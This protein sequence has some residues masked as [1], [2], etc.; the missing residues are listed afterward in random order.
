MTLKPKK[1]MRPVLTPFPEELVDLARTVAKEYREMEDGHHARMR[2]FLGRAYHV[3]R[4]FQQV[5]ESFEELKRDPFWELSRQKPKGLTTSKWVLLYV[6]RAETRNAR[7]RA[8]TYAKILDGF[9]RKKVRADQVPQ[10]IKKLGGIPLRIFAA[11][12]HQ[13]MGLMCMP[14]VSAPKNPSPRSL[15]PSLA[16]GRTIKDSPP[17]ISTAS[18]LHLVDMN[19]SSHRLV[20]HPASA[21]QPTQRRELFPATSPGAPAT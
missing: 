11:R 19:V 4:S 2:A 20:K 13:V 7:T 12:D 10:R 1:I 3:Y 17:S 14:S 6:M 18:R 21:I 9:A 16:G 8:S 5:P 15:S